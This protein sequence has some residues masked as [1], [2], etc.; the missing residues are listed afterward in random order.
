MYLVS[1]D[2]QSIRNLVS[3]N[4]L[5]L[6]VFECKSSQ[7]M[8]TRHCNT[9]LQCLYSVALIKNILLYLSPFNNNSYLRKPLLGF[10][11]SSV[12]E[13]GFPFLDLRDE[14]SSR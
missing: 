8:E 10:L 13:M 6:F 4:S 12:W 14:V 5:P 1:Q 11:V 2:W 9:S 3:H 7:R